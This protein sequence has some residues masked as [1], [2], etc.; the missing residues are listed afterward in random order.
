MVGEHVEQMPLGHRVAREFARHR[1][2]AQDDDAVGALDEFFDVGG[3]EQDG[4]ALPGEF[5]DEALDLGLGADV[6]AAGGFVEQQHLGLQA[7]PAGEEYLLLVAAG[8][9]ADLLL[10]ARRLDPQPSHEDV[11]DAVL[12][13]AGDHTEAGEPRHGGQHDVLAH[14]EAGHDA[15]GLAVLGQQ[16]D[17]GTDGTGRA[18]AAQF[19]SADRDVTGIQAEH[20]GEGL[21]RLAAAGAEQPAEPEHFAAVQRQGHVVEL[22]APV[23]SG[24]GEYGGACRVVL[25]AAQAGGSGAAG[26][27]QIAAEHHRDEPRPVEA[28]EVAGVDVAAVAEHGD[29]VAD[30]VELVHAVADVEDGDALA[31]QVPDDVEEGLDLARFQRG[32]GFVHD[33]GLGVH[34]DRS[35]Q[36][37]H[38]PGADA[39]HVQG[40]PGV[41]VYAEAVEQLGGLAVHAG[42]VDETEAVPGLAA[43][44]DVP[45]HAHQRDEVHLL[46]DGGDPGPLGLGRTGEGDGSS[47]EPEPS[48]SGW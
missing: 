35:G 32:G 40:L 14:G 5:V 10:G 34:R 44:E 38:L 12:F 8:E 2:A 46:V 15:F 11:D 19:P 24:G 27:G 6:D 33:D 20:S 47:A 36:G 1:A 37:D 25:R 26:L 23:E 3:D 48:P 17:P 22:V 29:A 21:R 31:A 4:E 16:A 41:D 9:F 43:E 30:P 42:E 7:E 28:D 13:A 39:E 45:R 18:G